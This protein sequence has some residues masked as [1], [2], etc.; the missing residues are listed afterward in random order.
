MS[1]LGGRQMTRLLVFLT[2]SALTSCSAG[3]GSFCAAAKPI[4]PAKGETVML[5]SQLRDGVLEHNKTGVALC[6]WKP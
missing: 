2:L 3:S 5:S 4:R 6:G 1:K